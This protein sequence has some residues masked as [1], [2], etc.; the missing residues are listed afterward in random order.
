MSLYDDV[1]D[2][3]I[4]EPIPVEDESFFRAWVW[5]RWLREALV[6][7]AP[8]PGLKL[9]LRELNTHL[10]RALVRHPT[11]KTLLHWKDLTQRKLAQIAPTVP[12]ALE[13]LAAPTP[14]WDHREW[15]LGWADALYAQHQASL[16]KGSE[17]SRR[18][19]WAV[20]PLEAWLAD[21]SAHSHV[22]PRAELEELLAKTKALAVAG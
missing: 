13:A 20:A 15:R 12:A 17:A 18:A 10:E 9:V 16:G 6:A 11:H 2:A 4:G 1:D 19:A 7:R 21:A 5:R 3:A 22:C 8:E 14:G